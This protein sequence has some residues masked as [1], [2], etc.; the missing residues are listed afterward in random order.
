MLSP[1]DKPIVLLPQD[2]ALIEALG[3][4]EADYRLFIR[5]CAK[6]SQIRPGDPTMFD[7][8]LFALIFTIVGFLIQTIATLFFK[9]K[10]SQPAQ[11]RQTSNPG[12]NVVG[13]SEYAPK[14][15]F[16]SLQNV[17]E[18]GSTIPLV[19]A[20]RETI[21]GITYGGVRVNASLLWSQMTSRGGSQML[22]A[23][24]AIS[25]GGIGA[26]DPSQFAFGDNVLGGYDLADANAASS[27]VTFYVSRDGGRLRSTDRVAGRLAAND[28]GNAENA[29]GADVFQTI[30]LNGQWTSDFCYAYKP[31]TQTQFGV[32]SLIGNGLAFRVNPSLRPNT[33][34]KSEPAGE[35]D[36]R[37]RCETDGVAQAQRDKYNTLFASRS[38]VTQKNGVAASGTTALAVGDT[39]TYLLDSASEANR[40]FIG[41]QEG[42]DHEE[43]CRDVA[44]TV[45]G[46]QRSW[47]DALSI[48]E[49]YKLGS[50]LLV[51]E[52]RTPEDEIFV[53]EA[54]QE[55]I[56]GGQSMTVTL[57]CVQAG[58]AVLNAPTATTTATGSSH[59][60]K[61]AVANF[62]IPRSAQ[63][64]EIGLR[65]TLGIRI[66]GLCNFRDS[67]SEYEIDGRACRFFDGRTYRPGQSLELSNYQSGGFSGSE[68]RYSFF[69]VG[70]RIAGSDAAFTFLDPCFGCRSITQ[71]ATYNFIRLQMPSMQR[72]EFRLEPLCGWEIRNSI[73]TGD[74]EVL[75]ARISGYRTITS[76]SGANQVTIAYSGEP[77]ARN[78][79]TFAIAATRDKGLN[80]TLT[81]T[82][83]YADAW[84]K[85]AE[86]FVFEEIQTSARSPENEV[87]YVNI[88]APNPNV[89]QY[90][91]IALV[92]MNL[93]SSTEFSQLSQ[94]SV[95][96]NAGIENVHT[97]PEVLLR[98]LSNPLWGTGN[99][100]SAAQIDVASFNECAAWT[101]NRRYF[102]DLAIDQPLNIR[103]YGSSTANFFL[104]EMLIKNGKFALQP[105]LYFDQP[106]PITGLYTA[107]N[108][109]EDSFEFAYSDIEQRIPN[110]ISVKWRQEKA[111]TDLSA[112]G[113]FPVIREV[114]VREAGTPEDAPLE[115]IDLT[116]F[117]TSEL[118][119]IDVAKLLC[120]G[121]RLVTHSVRFKTI[122]TQAALQVGR[123]F[124]LGL[125]TVAYDQPRN[126]A[127]DSNG[128]ITSTEP[129]ADG[130]YP[131][132]I[133]L[134]QAGGSVQEAQLV[135][136]G[137]RSATYR[138]AVFCLRESAAE[139]RA[140]KVQSLGFDEDGNVEVQ[141]SFFPLD[142][143]GYSLLAN[144]WD[145]EQNWIIEGRIGN[146][147]ASGTAT[148]V[149]TGV[150]IIGPGTVTV[151]APGTFAA[152]VSGSGGGYSYAW[153]GSGVTFGTANAASTTVTISSASTA[154]ITCAVTR[155]GVTR[156]AS[157]AVT[158]VASSNVG[159]IGT[160]TITGDASV[161]VNAP[162]AYSIG[163]TGK[164]ADTVAGA[165][166]IGQTYQIVSAGT[167]NFTLIGA[168]NS[169]V[170]T[171]FTAT[172]AGSGTGTADSLAAA[173]LSWGWSSATPNASATI[174]NSNAPQATITFEVAATYT[175]NCLIS[176]PGA[177]DTPQT[178]TLTVTVT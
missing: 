18:L 17:V 47:D 75:D 74:L 94:L 26:I 170:G 3:I 38:G 71:Q 53:S 31:S 7:F 166:T 8:G 23:V 121:R 2:R 10:T 36:I 39:I 108:I 82:G 77:V 16:D 120:R 169:N 87:V 151:N 122:P 29:G 131:V 54:D 11:I 115:S 84:G 24:F 117:C 101:R 1:N 37:I 175:V 146:S 112:K 55:P 153:T 173:F 64:V 150:S 48:G 159:A 70:Y 168:A 80:V 109:I 22:R 98:L 103:Q 30:G 116:D 79:A 60:L 152:L 14:A 95:Y 165:F 50:A 134:G 66:S 63:V 140:Y 160:A 114:T 44:Q 20:K 72:W 155:A 46:R 145:A 41:V 127:I 171:V 142:A 118:H 135:V 42:P 124:K 57:R 15:G 139:T 163:Y 40:K 52:T 97:F 61:V 110:R 89:P 113:L 102:Y 111:T 176:R 154:T 86:A 13:R 27:R 92:G 83:D 107:G 35:R 93:R 62:A 137:Q 126:G 177:S 167:T 144:G 161:S 34:V 178:A 138:N 81:E 5:E 91:N 129:L 105:A 132:L 130:V 33:V 136:Q 43:T 58:T 68:Q 99:T 128:V 158:A 123:C 59:L 73:A 65:S 6:R 174:V 133:W 78:A 164:P 172:G 32:Y 12:Q 106:E 49:L 45:S 149:F 28:P 21:D 76:G 125:E 148:A 96:V 147:E 19:F 69:K 67:L 9:P 85:L 88:L 141:A 56:G 104:L 4:S 157:K 156:S 119:A 51:C 25:E 143:N 100:L 90:D 162:E